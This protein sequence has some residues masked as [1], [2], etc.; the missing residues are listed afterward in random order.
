[1]RSLIYL[2]YGL[3]WC[4]DTIQMQLLCTQWG[5]PHAGMCSPV[6]VESGKEPLSWCRW[7]GCHSKVTLLKM[8]SPSNNCEGGCASVYTHAHTH[9][10]MHTHTHA[11]TCT[12]TRTRAHT[13]IHT[14]TH[15]RTH[16]CIHTHTHAHTRTHTHTHTERA[17]QDLGS[18]RNPREANGAR[19]P[20]LSTRL[21]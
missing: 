18:G 21:L 15:V 6:R 11:Y 3:W 19:A 8:K 5:T 2:E 9:T 1:M 16:T 10:H 17:Q 4:H 12:N 20:S 14:R 7:R 13:C